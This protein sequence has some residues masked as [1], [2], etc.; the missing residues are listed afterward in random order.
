MP[1]SAHLTPTAVEQLATNYPSAAQILQRDS[2]IV[3]PFVILE[4]LR[5]HPFADGNGRMARQL[6]LRLRL[7]CCPGTNDQHIRS[8]GP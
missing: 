8:P 5:I 4:L 2:A 3:L 1:E 6:T 7:K